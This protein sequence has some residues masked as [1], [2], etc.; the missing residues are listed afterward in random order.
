ME[1][2]NNII[3]NDIPKID[4]KKSY[5][6]HRELLNENEEIVTVFSYGKE[7]RKLYKNKYL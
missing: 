1:N 4:I 7:F 6:K 2:L 3:N 5:F